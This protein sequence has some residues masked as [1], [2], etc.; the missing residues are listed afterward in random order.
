MKDQS[1]EKKTLI[2]KRLKLDFGLNTV[3]GKGTLG[4]TR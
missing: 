3:T 2:W 4:A 1:G